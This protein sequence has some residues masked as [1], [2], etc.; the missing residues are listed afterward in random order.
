MQ[1][2]KFPRVKLI[3]VGITNANASNILTIYSND[4]NEVRT[5]YS[6]DANSKVV[7]NGFIKNLRIYAAIKS[8]AEVEL[9]NFDLGESNTSKQLKVLNLEWKSPRKQISVF[10][11]Q[12]PS[13]W[14]LLGSISLLNPTGYPYRQYNLLDLIT[15]NLAAEIGEFGRIGVRLDDV[16]YGLLGADDTISLYGSVTEEIFILDT[17]PDP[18]TPISYVFPRTTP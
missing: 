16:G 18:L 9:P 15:D 5:S 6:I 12:L 1:I 8:L 3:Q 2:E 13:D 11:G 7:L 4:P 14:Q 10:V 17:E